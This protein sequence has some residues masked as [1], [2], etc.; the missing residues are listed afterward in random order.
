MKKRS[1]ETR[2]GEPGVYRSDGTHSDHLHPLE[3]PIPVGKYICAV[4][5]VSVPR[6]CLEGKDIDLAW[7]RTLFPKA[8]G[9]TKSSTE[10]THGPTTSSFLYLMNNRRQCTPDDLHDRITKRLGFLHGDIRV[11]V[12]TILAVPEQGGHQHEGSSREGTIREHETNNAINLI[13]SR[14]QS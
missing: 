12:A 3:E 1:E 8:H 6:Y 14:D 13:V 4:M 2:P 11:T 9:K 7:T 10:P 5:F